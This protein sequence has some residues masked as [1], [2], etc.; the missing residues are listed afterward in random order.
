MT[1]KNNINLDYFIDSAFTKYC[2]LYNNNSIFNCFKKSGF[3]I[4]SKKSCY[5]KNQYFDH[6]DKWGAFIFSVK[7]IKNKRINL[8]FLNSSK[9]IKE[10]SI[11]SYKNDILIEKTKNLFNK[12]IREVKIKDRLKFLFKFYELSIKINI[13]QNYKIKHKKIH[14]FLIKI[15]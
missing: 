1:T 6:S 5:K 8:N 11:K 15:E 7:R 14:E 13:N 9:S 12:K 2:W 4:I 10:H 3:K